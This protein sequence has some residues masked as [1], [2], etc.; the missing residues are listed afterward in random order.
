MDNARAARLIAHA[1]ETTRARWK[2]YDRTWDDIDRIFIHHGYEQQGFEIFKFL[3]LLDKRG[4]YSIDA[5]GGLIRDEDGSKYTR[6]HSGR[7]TSPFY[8]ALQRGERGEKGKSLYDAIKEFQLPETGRAGS[9][10][11]KLIWQLLVA[12]RYLKTNH[13]ASFR[14]YILDAFSKFLGKQSITE[15]AFLSTTTETWNAFERTKPWAPLMGVGPNTFAFIFRD[16]LEAR[17]ASESY[18]LDKANLRFFRVT[19]IVDLFDNLE[20]R[21]VIGFLRGLDTDYTL[22]EINKGI[23]TYCSKTE[24]DQFGYCRYL[25]DCKRCEVNTICDRRI[26]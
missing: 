24:G 15:D 26:A 17:F 19:G 2:Q 25:A 6:H 12:C 18:K 13:R 4:C 22:R 21:T 5:L 3:P 23:Y 8:I 11:W 14:R 1:V 16:I 9:C 7:I 10:F 20:R